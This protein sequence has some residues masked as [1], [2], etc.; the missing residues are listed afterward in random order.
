MIRVE[1]TI[2][3]IAPAVAIY[4][5]FGKSNADKNILRI[6][7]PMPNIPAK[8]PDN[9]PPER[10]VMFPAGTLNLAC[11]PKPWRRREATE[12]IRDMAFSRQ[13]Y[14]ER[15]TSVNR[16]LLFYHFYSFESGDSC[17]CWISGA[18]SPFAGAASSL[19]GTLQF[20]QLP[21]CSDV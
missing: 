8:N 10:A 21:I 9:A 20:G 16:G 5:A 18:V 6:A 11:P 2:I 19:I 12:R 13:R 3:P 15:Q 17:G 14:L 4:T 7:P 1:S